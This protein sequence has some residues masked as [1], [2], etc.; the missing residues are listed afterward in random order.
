MRDVSEPDWTPSSTLREG[1]LEQPV[2]PLEMLS[3]NEAAAD[4]EHKMALPADKVGIQPPMDLVADTG[5]LTGIKL[6]LVFGSLM[7]CVLVSIAY[8]SSSSK[9]LR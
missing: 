5:L 8:L 6:Y 2:E 7:L 1:D 3:M 9:L 4:T